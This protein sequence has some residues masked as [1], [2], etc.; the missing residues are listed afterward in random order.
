MSPAARQLAALLWLLT[1]LLVGFAWHAGTP[2]D[3][4]ALRPQLQEA[5]SFAAETAQLAMLAAQ[6]RM[7]APVME[8]HAG[9]LL[10]H[11]R[12]ATRDLADSRVR[13][14]LRGHR[15]AA[16]PPLLAVERALEQLQAGQPANAAALG[17]VAS[18][19]QAQV[20]A[21]DRLAQ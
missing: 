20:K 5:H 2:L 18:D 7:P 4:A 14:E 1:S 8:R 12:Q 11:V 17:R 13:D 21:L 15:D 19:L 16:R 10:G 6:G 3:A 9:L